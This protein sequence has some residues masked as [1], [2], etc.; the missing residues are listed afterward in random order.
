MKLRVTAISYLLVA[1]VMALLLVLSFHVRVGAT[2]DSVALLKTTGMTCSSCADSIVSAL[3][4]VE[5]VV[6]TEVEIAGGWVVVG[7]ET[8]AV[9]P[10]L[11]ARTVS[12]AGYASSVSRVMSPIEYR[13]L[14][15]KDIGRTA[16]SADGC[17]GM[18]KC[19]M[20]QQ[21]KTAEGRI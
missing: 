18:G 20:T 13:Q 8:R 9:T 5:G 14:S 10:E 3:K 2:A 21:K 17:C 12:G 16:A 6:A 15:G 4:K 7:Y 19:G 11:L 1:G